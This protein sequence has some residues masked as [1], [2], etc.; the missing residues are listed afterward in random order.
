MDAGKESTGRAVPKEQVEQMCAVPE[1]FE[2]SAKNGSAGGEPASWSWAV[3]FGILFGDGAHSILDA[4]C[5]IHTS[6]TA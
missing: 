3:C 6:S 1:T 2:L 5:H 4:L